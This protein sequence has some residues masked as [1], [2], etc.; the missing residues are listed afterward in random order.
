MARLEKIEDEYDLQIFA[1]Y[2]TEKRAGKTKTRPFSEFLDEIEKESGSKLKKRG[3]FASGRN[4][5]RN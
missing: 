3:L 1:E 5:R 4:E 2:E